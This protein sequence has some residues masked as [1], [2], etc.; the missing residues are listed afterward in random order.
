M[1]AKAMFSVQ[2]EHAQKVGSILRDFINM[3]NLSKQGVTTC[4]ACS[5]I[6]RVWI[7]STDF[8]YE[9]HKSLIDKRQQFPLTAYYNDFNGEA[10]YPLCLIWYLFLNNT[11]NITVFKAMTTV[12]TYSLSV[13]DSLTRNA[14]QWIIKSMSAE[15]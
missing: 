4:A 15:M 13:D 2:T 8:V 14:S 3:I 9:I 7:L 5:Y 12:C 6:K 1:Y 11:R 10:E